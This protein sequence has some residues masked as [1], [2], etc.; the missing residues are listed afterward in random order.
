MVAKLY[1]ITH[2]TGMRIDWH[3]GDIVRKLRETANKTQEEV[4][5]KANVRTATMSKLERTGKFD[6]ETL[7]K[8]CNALNV[9]IGDIYSTIDLMTKPAPLQ[10]SD[11]FTCTHPEH[12]KLY[13]VFEIIF[14]RHPR[15]GAWLSG[16]MPEFL[17]ALGSEPLA[18]P[19]PKGND[20]S[21][22]VPLGRTDRYKA[23]DDAGA[24]KRQ[25]YG[26]R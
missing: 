20:F 13:E 9:E 11:G 2:T 24:A 17:A 7:K 4:A 19:T 18:G 10:A 26:R 12:R 15:I 25:K 3:E 5:E 6:I 1:D 23:L 22:D 16:S 21:A 14:E 8:V